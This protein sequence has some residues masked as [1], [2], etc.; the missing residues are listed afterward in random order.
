MNT[1]GTSGVIT[2]FCETYGL[3]FSDKP[4]PESGKFI[5][6]KMVEEHLIK[7]GSMLVETCGFNTVEDYYKSMEKCNTVNQGIKIKKIQKETNKLYV[8]IDLGRDED[9]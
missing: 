5:I 2:P 3:Y 9:E 8:N 4:E 6:D 1:T 7:E